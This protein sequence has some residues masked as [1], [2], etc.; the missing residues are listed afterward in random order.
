MVAHREHRHGDAP[1]HGRKAGEQDQGKGRRE[2]PWA[3][4]LIAALGLLLVIA[5]AGTLGYEA[6][7]G[8]SQPPAVE[9]NVR[10]IR[11]VRAG[12]LVEIVAVNHGDRTGAQVHITGELKQGDTVVETSSTT[13]SYVPGQSEQQG[14]LFFTK[15]PR[16]YRIQV[17]ATGYEKP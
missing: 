17:R 1:R 6:F 8:A 5:S 4:K 13:F 9:V 7:R 12:Y 14:G 15:D 3:E 10:E 16:R 2:S 11:D